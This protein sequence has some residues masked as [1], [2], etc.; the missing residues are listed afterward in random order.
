MFECMAERSVP[1]IMQERGQKC[2]T[3]A[4][5]IIVALLLGDDVG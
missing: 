1:D 2:N 5:H 4:V 3:F